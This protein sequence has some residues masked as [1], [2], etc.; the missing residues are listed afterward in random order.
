ML[1]G[2]A[3]EATDADQEL[4]SSLVNRK[5][6]PLLLLQIFEGL[7]SVVSKLLVG[8]LHTR[9]PVYTELAKITTSFAPRGK[10]PD[11][12]NEDQAQR[13]NPALRLFP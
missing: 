8:D 13:A 3:G 9:D 7:P 5:L 4:S 11:G 1:V 6:S 12:C 10:Q 2:A